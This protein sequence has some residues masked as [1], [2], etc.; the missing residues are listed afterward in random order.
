MRRL[1]S[2][3]AVLLSTLPVL[4]HTIR[5]IRNFTP[6]YAFDMKHIYS[7]MRTH[8]NGHGSIYFPS[9]VLNGPSRLTVAPAF[10]HGRA[11]GSMPARSS[12]ISLAGLPA[13]Q[14]ANISPRFSFL[15]VT[16]DSRPRCCTL[17]IESY[18][19]QN[20][21]VQISCC[22]NYRELSDILLH[23]YSTRMI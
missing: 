8:A 11:L 22:R 23:I 3:L 18:I 19:Y 16:A 2:P 4:Y 5:P 1:L 9:L 14:Q 15:P 21:S 17:Q 7:D 10:N 6:L 20:A 12:L 13:T